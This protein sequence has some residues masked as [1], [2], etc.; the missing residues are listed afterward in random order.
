MMI[1]T[2]CACLAAAPLC[3]PG[4]FADTTQGKARWAQN[5]VIEPEPEIQIIEPAPDVRIEVEQPGHYERQR[6]LVKD[7]YYESYNVWVPK[8]R[9]GLFGLK[10]IPGHYEARQRWI[11]PVYEYRD[12]WVPTR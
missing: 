3:S 2:V 12:V 11:P 7:G 6:V 5:I 10:V 4:A 1:S 8:D 9:T